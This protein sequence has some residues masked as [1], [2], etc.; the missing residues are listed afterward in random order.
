LAEGGGMRLQG[1]VVMRLDDMW[2]THPDQDNS[3]VCSR[4]GARVG[5]YP[6][7]Q[8]ALKDHPGTPVICSVCAAVE[9]GPILPALG[10]IEEA[11]ER[12]RSRR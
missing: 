1:L 10:S 9:K 6:S 2:N 5:I 8:R 12:I 3:H 7:G 11:I 4:C